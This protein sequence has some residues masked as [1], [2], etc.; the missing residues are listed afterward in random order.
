MHKNRFQSIRYKYKLLISLILAFLVPCIFISVIFVPKIRLVE[1]ENNIEVSKQLFQQSAYNIGN[2]FSEIQKLSYQFLSDK[3]LKSSTGK[4][5]ITEKMNACDAIRNYI[6]NSDYVT[7]LAFYSAREDKIYFSS[8][9]SEPEIYFDKVYQYEDFDL[10]NF[11]QAAESLIYPAGMVKNVTAMWNPPQQM[12][13]VMAPLA[14]CAFENVIFHVPLAAI[15]AFADELLWDTSVVLEF[16][17]NGDKIYTNGQGEDTARMVDWQEIGEEQGAIN[18]KVDGNQ[19]TLLYTPEDSLIQIV[20]HR[21]LA[22]ADFSVSSISYLYM[23]ILM[24]FF[25]IGGG[26]ILIIWRGNYRPVA[27]IL[28]Y[29]PETESTRENEFDLVKNTLLTIKTEQ[30]RMSQN[31][32]DSIPAYK[33]QLLTSLIKGE[34]ESIGEF[35]KKADQAGFCL[36]DDNLFILAV[37]LVD[38]DHPTNVRKTAILE[39][40]LSQS[41]KAMPEHMLCHGFVDMM[42]EKIIYVASTD[43]TGEQELGAHLMEFQRCLQEDIGFEL[44]IGCSGLCRE[45]EGLSKAY[46]EALS[47]LDYRIVYGYGKLIFFSQISLNNYSHN[48]YPEELARRFRIALKTRNEEQVHGI[49]DEIMEELH[50]NNTPVY[51]AKYVCY[52]L[53][54]MLADSLVVAKSLP[55]KKTIGYH[56]IMNIARV[57]SFG[58]I[59]EIL[60]QNVNYVLSMDVKEETDHVNQEMKQRLEQYI[61]DN[62]SNSSF[63]MTALAEEFKVSESTM[64]KNFKSLMQTTF[65]EYLAEKRISKSKELLS[66]TELPLSQI[67]SEVGY[68]DTSSFIRRFRQKTGMP[69]GE[70]RILH[71]SDTK[72]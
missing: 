28:T 54:Q 2:I 44:N 24:L 58:Q 45:P 59:T 50:H 11:Y 39:Q 19:M 27:E 6:L 25:L 40:I 64:R 10:G 17:F 31:L 20:L 72:E 71:K 37:S 48:W 46:M 69:P 15:T 36:Q 49:L 30:E 57:S 8:G 26:A 67:A 32:M 41:E 43:L 55:Y 22:K 70:Y 63:S 68:Q 14:G 53:M 21:N 29:I 18:T 42:N 16:Y 7:E 12:V 47:A 52:D 9:T 60:H 66:E 1:K 35:N 3:N 33:K 65:I 61:E 34:Y 38:A 62:Y 5:M 23:M 4:L 51:V 56:N 13:V